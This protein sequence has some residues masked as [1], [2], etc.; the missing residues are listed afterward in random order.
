MRRA[1]DGSS[2]ELAPVSR[3]GQDETL[4]M[5][6]K[7]RREMNLD[8]GRVTVECPRLN[9]DELADVLAAFVEEVRVP[10]KGARLAAR[11]QRTPVTSWITRRAAVIQYRRSALGEG[12]LLG[13]N[14]YGHICHQVVEI[15]RSA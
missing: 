9:D 1:V 14:D 10:G 4:T 5:P 3:S 13:K 7:T 2:A 12:R 6:A 11:P 8:H 15:K